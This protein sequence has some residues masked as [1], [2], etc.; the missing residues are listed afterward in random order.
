MT[1][2]LTVKLTRI[3]LPLFYTFFSLTKQKTKMINEVFVIDL[4]I[5]YE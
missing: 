3:K 4:I 2:M 1:W 5:N